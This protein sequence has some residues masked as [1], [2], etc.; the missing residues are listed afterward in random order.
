M[1]LPKKKH[2][3]LIACCAV[4]ILLLVV[5]AILQTNGSKIMDMGTQWL[6]VAGVPLLIALIVG[7]YITKFKGFGLEL[8]SKLKT[9]IHTL[10]LKATDVIA[11]LPGDDK[12]SSR[13]LEGLTQDQ[14]DRTKRLSF[15]TGR[16]D[17]YV[18]STIEEYLKKL[19]H[20]EYLEVKRES[21]EFV[22]LIP[23]KEFK[24]RERNDVSYIFTQTEKFRH[25]LEENS[26]VSTYRHVCIDMTVRQDESLISVLEKLRA[27]NKNI[28]VV[29]DSERQFVGL[30][31]ASE[32]EHRI[33]DDVLYSRK[34]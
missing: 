10:S 13:Y 32:I 12:Q 14:I 25:A 33:A 11:S 6:L 2:G 16:R 34:A 28:V 1:E 7:G 31:T 29:V 23:I 20:L 5:F 30:L 21:G 9:P 18:V 15:I 19:H 26:V 8:E 24:I 4:S 22:C 3:T 17:Y 27:A